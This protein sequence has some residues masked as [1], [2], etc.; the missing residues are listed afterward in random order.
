MYIKYVKWSKKIRYS[1]FR[2]NRNLPRSRWSGSSRNVPSPTCTVSG[3][4]RCVTAA[5]RLVIRDWDPS[6]LSY[7][8]LMIHQILKTYIERNFCNQLREFISCITGSTSGST[9]WLPGSRVPNNEELLA[10]RSFTETELYL[11]DSS[12]QT[13]SDVRLRLTGQFTTSQWQATAVPEHW[14]LT[15]RVQRQVRNQ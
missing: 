9:W 4:K 15:R 5:K 3:E 10:Q 8:P 1:W 6:T 11:D 12:T 14:R 7:S 2:D 13:G